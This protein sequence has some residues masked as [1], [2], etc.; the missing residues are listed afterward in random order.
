[1]GDVAIAACPIRPSANDRVGNPGFVFRC[2]VSKPHA[3]MHLATSGLT[4]RPLGWPWQQVALNLYEK[5]GWEQHDYSL[6]RHQFTL[7]SVEGHTRVN[8]SGLSWVGQG[9]GGVVYSQHTCVISRS[10][11]T[12]WM[13]IMERITHACPHY[14][15]AMAHSLCDTLMLLSHIGE[16]ACECAYEWKHLT[17][18]QNLQHSPSTCK[19]TKFASHSS[20]AYE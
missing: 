5:E 1:M 18:A 14:T 9:G 7:Y 13:K 2:N 20:P 11:T 16:Y 8:L 17:F 4:V 15:V 19:S 12:G 3:I 10:L 6:W